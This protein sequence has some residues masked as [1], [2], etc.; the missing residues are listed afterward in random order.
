MT[1]RSFGRIGLV[2]L[3]TLVAAYGAFVLLTRQDGGNLVN[4]AT[5][6]V[7]GVVLHD[8]LL[9]PVTIG[10]TLLALR[11]LPAPWWRPA[12]VALVVLGPLTLLTVPV[13]GGFGAQPD[14][15]GLQE[16]PYVA[17]WLAVVAVTV[18]VVAA[19]GSWQRRTGREESDGTRPR[20]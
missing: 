7:G 19:V 4:A 1:T 10:V 9:A 16:R 11:A 13:L 17:S 8:G 12:V 14:D 18:L 20:R 6:L 2:G 15:P 3:G 5:W